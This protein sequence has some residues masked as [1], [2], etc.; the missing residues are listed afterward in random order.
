VSA[1]REGDLELGAHAVGAGDQ[2]R[3]LVLAAQQVDFA[4]HGEK[5]GETADPAHHLRAVGGLGEPSDALGDGVGALPVHAG[6]PVAKSRLVPAVFSHPRFL[7]G[8][9][10]F[11]LLLR[12]KGAAEKWKPR[13][14]RTEGRDAASC[15]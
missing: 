7:A 9:A 3:L 10:E 2:D 5:S 12:P 6:L 15:T 4:A 14:P 8:V 1:G 13:H 11:P